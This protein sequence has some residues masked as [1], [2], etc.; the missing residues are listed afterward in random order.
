ML[1][2]C[3]AI[4]LLA[5][6]A[7]FLTNT[8]TRLLVRIIKAVAVALV[9]CAFAEA[10]EVTVAFSSPPEFEG[11]KVGFAVLQVFVTAPVVIFAAL[12]SLIPHSN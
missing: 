1:S 12:L 5:A 8:E 7:W 11:P 10:Y 9:L 4:A 3:L 6:S 2:L